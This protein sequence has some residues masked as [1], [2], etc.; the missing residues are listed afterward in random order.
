VYSLFAK[1]SGLGSL[2]PDFASAL[3][4]IS[5]G[6]LII[7]LGMLVDNAIVVMESI[8]RRRSLGDSPIE[9]AAKG[10]GFVGG[11]IVASTLTTCVVFLPILFVE[12]MAAKLISGISFTVVSSLI[13]SLLV[14]LLLIPALSVWLLPKKILRDVDPGSARLEGIV[15]TLMGS[16]KTVVLVTAMVAVIA[17][18]LLSRLGTELLPPSDPR[19]FA[20]RVLGPVG[21]Q[22]ESTSTM[23][24]NI[25]SIIEQ[26]AG[27]DLRATMSE[28]GR[29][30]EDDRLIREQQ[31]EEKKP[32]GSSAYTQQLLAAKERARQQQL[33]GK[34]KK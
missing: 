17:I 25:E 3:E 22:V 7:A 6:A 29:L 9:A 18:T 30:D 31:T 12:G 24:A 19:Q 4:R 13:A 14:A 21:Q 23:V 8:F 11:A 20:M 26:A 28:V 1:S 16:P 10:T 27:E 33:R 5:L 34:D 32:T 15:Y 2:L